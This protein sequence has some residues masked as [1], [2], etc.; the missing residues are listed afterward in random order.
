ME[1]ILILH[2]KQLIKN[3]IMKKTIL[4]LSIIFSTMLVS[5]QSVIIFD[6]TGASEV[7]YVNPWWGVEANVEVVGWLQKDGTNAAD[8]NFGATIWRDNENPGYTGGGINLNLDISMYNKI[9]VD[10]SK[11]V[12]GN[13]QVELQDGETKKAYLNVYYDAN[14]SGGYGTGTWQ[15]LTFDIPDGWSHLTALLVA[16]HNVNTTD[17]PINFEGDNERHRMSWDN[18]IAFYD[19]Q[20]ESVFS[21]TGN[22]SE[23]ARWSTG[24]VPDASA[25]VVINGEVTVNTAANAKD[26]VV[27]SNARIAVDNGG[28]LSVENL[29]LES[30]D[31]GTASL[32]NNGTLT[33]TG[34]TTVQQYLTAKTGESNSDNWWYISS[35]VSGATS[36]S[37]LVDG[38]NNKFGYYNETNASYP[39]I[40][41]TDVILQAGR[42]YVAQINK[43]DT[44]EFTGTLNN[45][46]IA[47]TLTR[48]TAAGGP[49]GF[50][51]V[52]NPYPSH[53]HW[54]SITGFGTQS[55]RTDIRPTIWVRTRTAG[56]TMDFDT[57]DGEDGVTKGKSGDMNGYIAPMQAFWV[58]VHADNTS[59]TITFTNALRSAQDQSSADN[60]LRAPQQSNRQ[61]L[62]LE[63]SNGLNFDQMV[64][65]TN[66]A[67]Q[68][69]Y[70]FYDSDKM[71]ASNTAI[72][73]IYSLVAGRELVIDKRTAI[74]PGSSAIVG[75]RPGKTGVFTIRATELT[76]LE[77]LHVV[78]KDHIL[79][80]ETELSSTFGYEFTADET[81]TN[82]R[83]SVEFR[84]PS[85]LTAI[86]D[87]DAAANAQVY[88]ND[89]NH[90]TVQSTGL[91]KDDCISVYNLAGQKL[92]WKA[93]NGAN[94][95][96]DL[97][98]NAGVYIV[99]INNYSYKVIVK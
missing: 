7:G 46:D 70:D 25:N 82:E 22:W 45:G 32:I 3:N 38:S 55:A 58:K 65:S 86:D 66:T 94:T 19:N 53:I 31:T 14:G 42:G 81:P 11:R 99:K 26:V 30:S 72:P 63:V 4:L 96:V 36:A 87:V 52:G 54:N 37:I 49:R 21:G 56:G 48:T 73:E 2:G 75:F 61:I 78:L 64:I 12:S 41:T 23:I 47:V 98:L 77:K 28:S 43:T 17:N 67:A 20:S 15:T 68:N 57:F 8:P 27:R 18:V 1:L 44:Y 62:R 95:E 80:T 84:T 50:N 29:L 79:N 83:F 59:P 91:S 33:V 40:T 10:I 6:G 39:Q 88:V 35:P 51:L 89:A 74:E 76:N 92:F 34:T 93:S 90:I 5:A 24:E 16:P 97:P 60:R 9:S 71:S 69:G 13:V 85:T